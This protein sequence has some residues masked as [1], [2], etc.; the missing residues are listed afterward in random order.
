[1]AL[2]LKRGSS[3]RNEQ[4]TS[5]FIHSCFSDK[6]LLPKRICPDLTLDI[7]LYKSTDSLTLYVAK[8]CLRSTVDPAFRAARS[9]DVVRKLLLVAW[10]TTITT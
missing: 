8:Y 2:L 4:F 6:P 5:L 7:W 1:M 3:H 9:R 10:R